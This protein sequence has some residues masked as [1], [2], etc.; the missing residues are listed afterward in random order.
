MLKPLTGAL[1]I[2]TTLKFIFIFELL[3][4]FP[5]FYNHLTFRSQTYSFGDKIVTGKPMHDFKM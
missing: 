1:K 4:Q 2:P 3:T 5:Y